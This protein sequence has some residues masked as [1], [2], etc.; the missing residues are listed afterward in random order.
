MTIPKDGIL[1]LDTLISYSDDV[2]DEYEAWFGN[3]RRGIEQ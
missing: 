2:E 3:G 1:I